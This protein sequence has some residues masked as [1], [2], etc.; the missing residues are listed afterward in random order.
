MYVLERWIPE[1]F[2]QWLVV[3]CNLEV[4]APEDEV[5]CFLQCIGHGEGL[6]FDWGVARFSGVSKS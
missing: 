5:T 6:A 4:T 3:H 2:Q 1:D